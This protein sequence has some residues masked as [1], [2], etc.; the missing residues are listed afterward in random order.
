MDVMSRDI[1]FS[2][3]LMRWTMPQNNKQKGK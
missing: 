2:R 3:R 1:P